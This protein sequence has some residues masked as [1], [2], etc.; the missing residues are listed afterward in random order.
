MLSG[1]GEDAV[2]EA[3]ASKV[4]AAET[5][6]REEA[7]D[8]RRGGDERGREATEGGR[9]RQRRRHRHVLEAMKLARVAI[10]DER[11]RGRRR[12]AAARRHGWSG[13]G[14]RAKRIKRRSVATL[15]NNLLFS[16][17]DLGAVRCYLY[18]RRLIRLP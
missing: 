2:D 15:S 5:G 12:L 17:T 16:T 10:G 9:H 7:Y 6:Q 13:R 8:G 4:G 1:G 14:G 11:W 18:F 3:G